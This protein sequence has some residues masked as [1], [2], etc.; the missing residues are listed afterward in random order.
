MYQ[1]LS[2]L[3]LRVVIDTNVLLNAT[4]VAESNARRALESLYQRGYSLVI[5]AAIEAEA[6]DQLRRLSKKLRLHYDPVQIFRAYLQSLQILSL[7]HADP[8]YVGSINKADLVV[9]GAAIH[10]QGWILTGDTKFAA[11]CQT[12][13]VITRQ[14][15]D[16][17]T[18]IEL[19]EKREL[20]LDHFLTVKGISQFQGS[21]FARVVVGPVL[22][23]S[24]FAVCDVENLGC[25]YYAGSI[26]SW[27]FE[28][29]MGEKV[30]LKCHA[31]PEQ[32]W[33]VSV[34]YELSRNNGA[35]T[36][37]LRAAEPLG[38]TFSQNRTL[39]KMIQAAS[40][41]VV[42]FGH[43]AN[44]RDFLNGCLRR[45]VI[46]TS[47]INSKAWKA[48]V[49]IPELSPDPSVNNVLESALK[50]VKFSGNKLLLPTEFSFRY[51]WLS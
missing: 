49:S 29:S 28:T 41:G 36:A 19:L 21:L 39:K 27:V 31:K 47:T 26:S 6:I 48:I 22:S 9:V 5:D 18:S 13:D 11:E 25:I 46:S 14:P 34:S 1:P 43:R 10:Y 15:F 45:V 23:M 51:S 37:T 40:P 20:P 35:M 4:F 2:G 24:N 17:I 12:V 32:H 3:Q 30:A 16:V 7:P 50:K 8:Y 42:A 44:H 38:D 33:I